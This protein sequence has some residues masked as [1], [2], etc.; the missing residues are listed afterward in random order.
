MVSS[1]SLPTFLCPTYILCPPP[2][3]LLPL[4]PSHLPRFL[5][6]FSNPIIKIYFLRKR[7]LYT[8]NK[9]AELLDKLEEA[10]ELADDIVEKDNVDSGKRDTSD[11]NEMLSKV[12]LV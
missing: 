6:F 7:V 11:D 9:M 4:F 5:I 2:V 1:S 10:E 3:L 8:M 12:V